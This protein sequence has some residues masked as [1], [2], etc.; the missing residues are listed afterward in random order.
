M[1]RHTIQLADGHRVGIT[2]AGAGIP[3]VV[4]HGFSVEGF[5]YA[6]TLS[7]LVAMGF[8]VIAVDTAGHGGTRGLPTD[9]QDLKAYSELLGRVIDELGI[10]SCVLAGHSMGGRLV[11]Q[12]AADRPDR[13]IAVMLVDAIVGDTW[14]RMVYA[15][16]LAPPLLGVVGAALMLDSLT[17]LPVWRDPRQAVKLFRLVLPTIWSDAT[18]PWRLL[19][20]IVSILR[21]RSSRYALNQLADNKVPVFVMHGD[22][23]IAVPLRT[24]REAAERTDGTL[25]TIKGGGHS[26][27]LRDPETLARPWAIPGTPGLEHRIGGIEKADVT[28]AI[29]YDPENHDF[30][31]RTRQAKVDGIAA[32]IP[33]LTVDDPTGEADVLVLGWGSTYGPI[34]AACRD[35]RAL[36]HHVAQAHLRHLNPFPANTGDVLRRYRRVIIPEMNLGQ[37]ALLIRGKYLVDARAYNQVRGM[38]FRSEELADVIITEMSGPPESQPDLTELTEG[39]LT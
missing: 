23:D 6:Q 8:K 5:L 28:G 16:R 10:R 32:D 18:H 11:T 17:I 7:R 37:L 34:A 26:W 19:A 24:S 21:S 14:D 9:G 1:A 2:V 3:L 36:G 22:R 30:M 35:V 12:L 38:P 27:L 33:E 4:V 25:V 20:P 13:T 31:V 39:S 29:S 15:F